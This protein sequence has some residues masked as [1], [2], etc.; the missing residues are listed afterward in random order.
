MFLGVKNV[1]NEVKTIRLFFEGEEKK[2]ALVSIKETDSLLLSQEKT[3]YIMKQLNI[4]EDYGRV[5][6]IIGDI[7]LAVEGS[8][9]AVSGLLDVIFNEAFKDHIRKLTISPSPIQ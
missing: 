8:P 9:S 3:D 4:S 6:V 2:E 1:D 7:D 5:H